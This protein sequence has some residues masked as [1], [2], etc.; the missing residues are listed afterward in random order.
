M[1]RHAVFSED[2][3]DVRGAAAPGRRRQRATERRAPGSGRQRQ[4]RRCRDRRAASPRWTGRERQRARRRGRRRPPRAARVPMRRP[5]SAVEQRDVGRELGE[6]ARAQFIWARVRRPGLRS[7]CPTGSFRRR[8]GSHP[9]PWH[10]R[11]QFC[12]AFGWFRYGAP[13]CGDFSSFRYDSAALVVI[14]RLDHLLGSG[15][16]PSRNIA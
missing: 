16:G 1:C 3:I 2:A 14:T 13:A 15:H 12:R 7:R 9:H 4:R 11:A 8:S 6:H 10:A 5:G